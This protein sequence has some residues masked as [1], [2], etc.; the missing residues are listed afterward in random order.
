MSGRVAV[1]V[2]AACL[3]AALALPLVDID[4]TW[5]AVTAIAGVLVGALLAPLVTQ[6]VTPATAPAPMADYP[7]RQPST[8]K[9]ATLTAPQAGQS[10]GQ[11]AVR[12]V[13]DVNAPKQAGPAGG[14]WWAK[15][16][17]TAPPQ[18]G[19]NGTSAA[20]ATVRDLAG[21]TES[22]Q[23]VQ[24]PRCG[25]FR[26][27]VTAVSGGFAFRCRTDEHAWQWQPGRSWPPT[28]V[29]SRRRANTNRTDR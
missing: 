23:V 21:Y 18:A 8:D 15:T 14:Q 28:V 22:A 19:H 26:V 16:A 4:S 7:A 10:V 29:V 6:P 1:L 12:M 17:S 5:L 3:G 20:P 13:L 2:A 9:T 24:C 11:Q 27:D 25:S